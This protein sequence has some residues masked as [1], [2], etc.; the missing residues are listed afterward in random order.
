MRT[1]LACLTTVILGL[2]LWSQT[3]TTQPRPV[4]PAV[5]AVKLAPTFFTPQPVAAPAPAPLLLPEIPIVLCDALPGNP[6][7]VMR[8][9]EIHVEFKTPPKQ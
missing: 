5:R 2:P 4:P 9:T 1:A 8:G 7:L 3:G 6:I